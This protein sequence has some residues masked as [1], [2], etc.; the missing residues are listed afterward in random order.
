MAK[1]NS[2]Q[3]LLRKQQNNSQKASSHLYLTFL[4]AFIEEQFAVEDKIL[5]VGAGAG[6][7]ES[8]LRLN[9]VTRT[10]ILSWDE[11][12]VVGNIDAMNLP[13]IDNEFSGAFAVDALHHMPD[14]MQT[15]LEAIRVVKRGS[16]IVFIEPYVS[17]MSYPIY[18]LFHSEKTSWNLKYK[19]NE[20]V[21]TADPEDGDQAIAQSIFCDPKIVSYLKSQTEKIF[22]FRLQFISPLSFFA[23][24][25]LT[26]PLPLPVG[27]M[28]LILRIESLLSKKLLKKC[29]ARI[30]ITIDIK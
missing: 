6:I 27:I 26:R 7:S 24:G 20:M 19:P 17:W 15:I 12:T 9:Q 18:K 28:R 4:Y 22:D 25:G 16:K 21:V 2:Y 5:E 14:P 3:E 30:I 10:D 8:F 13:M 11:K 29:A 23:T 1:N